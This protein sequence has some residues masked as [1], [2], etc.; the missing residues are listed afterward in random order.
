MRTISGARKPSQ[1]SIVRRAPKCDRSRDP[2]RVIR[3]IPI[4]SAAT[5]KLMRVAE[6]EVV[7]T[8]QGSASHV[9]CEPLVEI[10]SAARSAR[11][12]P[13]RRRLGSFTTP[14]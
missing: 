8:N 7:S 9:I 14:A 13:L 2:G 1:T 6:P 10:T 11:R 4:T 5:T 3:P 12:G